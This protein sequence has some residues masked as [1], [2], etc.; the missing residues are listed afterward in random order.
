ME[1]SNSFLDIE[2]T[3]HMSDAE[4][5][6][7]SAVA[8]IQVQF[9]CR[10]HS[11][12][13]NSAYVAYVK[14]ADGKEITY[15]LGKGEQAKIGAYG[16][17]IEHFF[18]KRIGLSNEIT[19]DKGEFLA[20]ELAQTDLILRQAFELD[21]SPDV[22]RC[23]S[24]DSLVGDGCVFL[25]T[26][27]VNFEHFSPVETLNPFELFLT[28]YVTTSGTSFGLTE[29]DAVLHSLNEI[30]ERD[31]TSEFFI[32]LLDLGF[33]LKNTFHSVREDA[34]PESV[35]AILDQLK[36]THQP[37][38]L[39]FYMSR[40]V[41]GTFWAFCIARFPA[42]SPFVLPQW[43]AGSSLSCELAIYR[44]ISECLQMLD[45]YDKA[46]DQSQRNL[47]HHSKKYSHFRTIAYLPVRERAVGKLENLS[48][49]II[50]DLA[51]GSPASQ[52]NQI[53]TNMS[54]LGFSPMKYI[55]EQSSLYCVATVFAPNLERF[56]NITKGMFALPMA[57]LASHLETSV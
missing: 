55:V 49:W 26:I 13:R 39:E 57:Y 22:I 20:S 47:I 8:S 15:G 9:D 53:A 31:A 5:R 43:G 50:G 19:L 48:E 44:S 18:Y 34:L 42:S 32:S 1:K 27:Y 14:S 37:S 21:G 33:K 23:V 24:F 40:T 30:I 16:E 4:A 12:P 52:V 41:F 38:Q 45:C 28:R 2:R 17:C 51:I 36:K 6:I 56:Y 7:C 25:P 11:Y 29:V 54:R 10:F 3:I 46:N 35:L